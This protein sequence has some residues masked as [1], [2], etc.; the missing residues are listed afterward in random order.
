MLMI[1]WWPHY[2]MGI[3]DI[4]QKYELG[5][6]TCIN[7]H[8]FHVTSPISS[9]SLSQASFSLVQ[10]RSKIK[11]SSLSLF[12]A[13]QPFLFY[14]IFFSFYAMLISVSFYLHV[15]FL[16]CQQ[17]RFTFMQEKQFFHFTLLSFSSSFLFMLQAIF[18]HMIT[19]MRA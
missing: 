16:S 10:F 3:F 19:N 1:A 9:L 5:F 4:P 13:T 2:L 8:M 18:V 11:E 7:T 6:H 12:M 14:V 15:H 17:C